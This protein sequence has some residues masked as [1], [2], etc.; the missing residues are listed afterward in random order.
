MSVHV[1]LNLLNELR[2]PRL[3]KHLSLFCNDLMYYLIQE[4]EC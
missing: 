4:Q 2:N 3:A 1:L